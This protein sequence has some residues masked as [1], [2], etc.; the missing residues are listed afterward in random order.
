MTKYLVT[1]VSQRNTKRINFTEPNAKFSEIRFCSEKFKIAEV[2]S[3]V[4]QGYIKVNQD[5][6]VSS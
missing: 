6:S 4:T 1:K 5:H 2:I 3:N